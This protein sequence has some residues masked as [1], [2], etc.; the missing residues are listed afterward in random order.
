MGATMKILGYRVCG[1]DLVRSRALTHDWW[2]NDI[3]QL[4]NC[5]HN[6]DAFEDLPWPQV[7]REMAAA[8]PDAKF[9]LTVRA[10]EMAWLRSI[11]AL[12]GK[13]LW[14]GHKMIYGSYRV[15]GGHEADYLQVYRAHRKAVE[16]FFYAE[17]GG[18]SERLLILSMDGTGAEKWKQVCDFLDVQDIP[19]GAFPHVNKTTHKWELGGLVSGIDRV[20]HYIEVGLT[21]K[22]YKRSYAVFKQEEGRVPERDVEKDGKIAKVS[23]IPEV[24]EEVARKHRPR[25]V[26]RL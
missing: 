3:H 22:Y 24:K 26:G 18:Q 4:V 8:F 16:E 11:A 1:W 5:A 7:F 20:F 14:L 12:T 21:S 25:V 13:R 2:N 17:P 10:D 6:F 19:Q 15:G 9:I 23:E